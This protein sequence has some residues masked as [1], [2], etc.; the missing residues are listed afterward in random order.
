MLRQG[1]VV[2]CALALGACAQLLHIDGVHIE[3]LGPTAE[4]CAAQNKQ[5]DQASGQC[6]AKTPAKPRVRVA[7]RQPAPDPVSAI[8]EPDAVLDDTLKDD[9]KLI[10]GLVGLVRARSYPCEAI[11][12]VRPFET[13]NGFRLS[14]DHFRYK[15]A[16]EDKSG[17]WVISVE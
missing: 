16:I 11:S 7:A 10:S 17:R 15:Y 1:V 9:T 3:G 13:L 8:L 4:D 2:A 6:V 14:C 5:I 12:A